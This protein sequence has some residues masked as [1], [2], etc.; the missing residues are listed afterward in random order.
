MLLEKIKN[1]LHFSKKRE[2]S[3]KIDINLSTEIYSGHQ[4]YRHGIDLAHSHRAIKSIRTNIL[5]DKLTIYEKNLT[6][7]Y[8]ILS[9]MV[10]SEDVSPASVW[11]LDNFYLIQEQIK[12]IHINLPKNYSQYFPQVIHATPGFPRIYDILEKTIEHG[13]G[14]WDAENLNTFL[15]GYQTVTPLTLRELWAIPLMLGLA[16]LKKINHASEHVI[17]DRNDRH[18]ANIWADRMVEIAMT[19]PKKLVKSLAEM[20]T[21]ESSMSS[22]FLSELTRRL[23]I[24][25]LALPLSWIEQQLED[26]GTSIENLFQKEAKQQAMIQA[27]MSN[28]IDSLR[29]INSTNWQDFVEGVSI[30]NQKLQNDPAGIYNQMDFNTRDR[31]RHV[32]EKLAKRSNQL[33][34]TIAATTVELAKNNLPHPKK[35]HVG[36]YLIDEGFLQLEAKLQLKPSVWNNVFNSHRLP[37]LYFG[38]IGLTAII[39]MLLLFSLMLSYHLKT[40]WNIVFFVIMSI[41]VSETAKRFIDLIATFIVKPESLPRMDM[42]A[43]I[44]S[45]CRTLIVIPAILL[46][47]SHIH[48]LIKA[49]E[50]HFLG[51][52]GEN[53][54]YMLLTD[55]ADAS[56]QSMPNDEELLNET[57]AQ[58]IKLNRHY[59]RD[60][61]FFCH[62]NRVWNAS[63]NTWMGKE[64]KRGKLA[65]LTYFL[66]DQTHK[67]ISVIVGDST[68]FNSI[69][70]IITL[71]CD[72]QLPREA[73]QQYVGVMEHPLN[74]PVIDEKKLIVIKGHGI[75]Q[76][77]IA[78]TLPN[79]HPNY[80]TRLF[81]SEFGIDPY[82][83]NVSD[84]YQ[85][86]F[87]EGSFIGKGIYEVDCFNQVLQDRFLENRIL[88]HDLLEG[89]YLRSGYLS[90]VPLFEKAPTHYLAD[91]KRRMRWIRGDWQLLPWLF[92]KVKNIKNQIVSNPLSFL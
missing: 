41:A 82:T 69:K 51:N 88:S 22:A 60:I 73:V 75:I 39:L 30:V 8:Q 4:I 90:D 58:I 50:A 62:R 54:Y 63:E 15:A 74:K 3:E 23:Q 46:D 71:D 47:S 86:L 24:A 84:V 21:S 32:I 17:E 42:V 80:Y 33:E 66:R 34:Q 38:S 44:P 61:F 81:G 70:Y 48:F 16:V 72:T 57:K 7:A 26:E 11:L 29:R 56:A 67:N 37:F 12:I 52:R 28:S 91:S 78:E 87:D 6:R 49:L 2:W 20:S 25:A 79:T 18:L 85:D 13:D 65:E 77:R 89:C 9:T 1:W 14:R 45:D 76:P 40:I 83:R 64:R 10:I 43:G 35:S 27:T 68:L 19:E 53:L 92:P 59:S 55:F 5:L 36:Y 31:Y